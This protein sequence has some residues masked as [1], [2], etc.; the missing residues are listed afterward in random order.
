MV[1]FP[2]DVTSPFKVAPIAVILVAAAVFTFGFPI[3]EMVNDCSTVP[4]FS[5]SGPYMY[6]ASPFSTTL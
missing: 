5:S 1:A 6:E 3:T 4:P 2:S